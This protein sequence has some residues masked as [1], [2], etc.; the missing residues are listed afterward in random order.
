[1]DYTENTNEV[2]FNQDNTIYFSIIMPCYNSEAY[3]CDAIESIVKQTYSNWE[4]IA[5]NDGSTDKTLEMLTA[6]SQKYD[7]IKVYSKP[8]GGYVSAVNFGLDKITGDYFLL[9]GSDDKLTD[10]ILSDLYQYGAEKQP[11]CIAYRTLHVIDDT[12]HGLDAYT[13]FE[14]CAFSQHT[15]F[16]SYQETY[17]IH[18]AIF[19]V[20]DTSKC[21][22]RDILKGL[23]YFGTYGM[24]AD[25]IFSM[26][27]CHHA[28]S[29]MSI[30]VDGY[31]W[32]LRPDSLSARKTTFERE[33]DRLSN[34]IQF[35]EV[36][37]KV[38][39]NEITG[40]EKERFEW[41]LDDISS[42]WKSSTPFFREYGL[43]CKALRC[44]KNTKKVQEIPLDLTLKR[45]LLIHF[46]VLWKII[47]KIYSGVS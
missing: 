29:F 9:L 46:P 41:F 32:T 18:S 13:Q 37:Q 1:M 17:P 22:K 21:F 42:L 15:S 5:I 6:Y 7:Q 34:W 23:R 31:L 45:K 19:S 35:F 12:I 43:V 2:H 20:R 30:P 47:W 26:L 38:A 14:D 44:V 3:V 36:L 25:G 4:L 28:T 33:C 24:D 10:T 16:A 8:N 11:D 27:L 39:P 40:S